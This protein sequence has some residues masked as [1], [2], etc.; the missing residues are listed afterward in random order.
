MIFAKYEEVDGVIFDQDIPDI[1]DFL[2]LLILKYFV[3]PF[4]LFFVNHS[5]LFWPHYNLILKPFDFCLYA[6][7]GVVE[8]RCFSSSW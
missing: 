6:Y 5:Y 7:L 1:L 4:I 2:T 8:I 3:F